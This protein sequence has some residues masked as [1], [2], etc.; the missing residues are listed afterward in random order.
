ML[1]PA[2]QELVDRMAEDLRHADAAATESG[3]M[4]VLMSARRYDAG[5][6][7]TLV[8]AARTRAAEMVQADVT[9]IME[10]TP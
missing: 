3:A 9:A 7:V 1:S 8:D 5:D 6:I 4:R 2:K 10:S